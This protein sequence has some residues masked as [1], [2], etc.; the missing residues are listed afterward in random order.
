V[1]SVEALANESIT[2]DQ[3]FAL[4]GPASF[5][6][7]LNVAETT[8]STGESYLTSAAA[9]FGTADYGDAALLGLFGSDYV[10]IDPLEELLLGA[11]ASF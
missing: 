2:G 7:A 8:F 1:G 11:A 9:D 10:S 3:P 4:I 5:S 6:E